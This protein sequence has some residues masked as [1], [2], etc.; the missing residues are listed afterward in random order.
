MPI[1]FDWRAITMATAQR[2]RKLCLP[3][4]CTLNYSAGTWRIYKPDGWEIHHDTQNHPCLEKLTDRDEYYET[5]DKA[6]LE[7]RRLTGVHLQEKK[8]ANDAH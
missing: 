8:E 6:L 5:V 2:Y 1:D 7:W 3:D 4:G